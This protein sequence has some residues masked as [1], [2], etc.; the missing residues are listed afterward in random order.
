MSVVDFNENC[1]GAQGNSVIKKQVICKL[2]VVVVWP[3]SSASSMLLAEECGKYE[4]IA[5]N[6]KK[7]LREKVDRILGH[8]AWAVEPRYSYPA[9]SGFLV[10]E[11]DTMCMECE[12]TD[13]VVVVFVNASGEGFRPEHRAYL[14]RSVESMTNKIN[15][16]IKTTTKAK[17]ATRQAA[18]S[19]T[20][21][22]LATRKAAAKT[23]TKQSGKAQQSK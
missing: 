13:G 22:E 11:P 20:K 14:S 3:V 18:K 15:N 12:A 19:I 7:L 9:P 5:L 6:S 4:T 1:K 17:P 8:R 2:A 21:A 23:T 16:A 10:M